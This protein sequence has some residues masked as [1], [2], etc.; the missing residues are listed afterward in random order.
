MLES[1]PLRHLTAY[2]MAHLRN[3][4]ALGP[5]CPAALYGAWIGGWKRQHRPDKAVGLPNVQDQ[6]GC[7][8]G[9]C[10]ISGLLSFAVNNGR[11]LV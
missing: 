11:A 1:C 9:G 2:H 8:V 5:K 4:A 3:Q 7:Q 10:G 6:A